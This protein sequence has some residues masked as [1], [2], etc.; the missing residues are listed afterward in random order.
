MATVSTERWAD[1]A[2]TTISVAAGETSQ[3]FFLWC[4]T[5]IVVLTPGVGGSMLASASWSPVDDIQAGG[6]NWN[7]WDQGTVTDP[8]SDVLM[9]A[10]AIRITA[11]AQ[12]GVAEIRQ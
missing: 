11:T 6:G 12:P 10:T 8:A 3:P 9:S 2:I 4:A 7:T 1:Q 5:A